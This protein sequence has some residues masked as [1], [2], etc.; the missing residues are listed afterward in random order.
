MGVPVI[1]CSC[2]VCRSSLPHN[3]RT[4]SGSLITI[5]D[6]KILIDASQ[7]F[8]DQALRF[9][10]ASIDAIFFT[11]AHYDHTAGIDD[12]RA[13]KK[14]LP[15]YMSRSTYEDLKGRYGYIFEKRKKER[16][17]LVSDFEISFLG[18]ERGSVDICAVSFN[19]MTYEQVGMPVNGFVLGNLGY[20]S[21]I[22]TYPTTIFEDL[23]GVEIL[24]VSALRQAPS[25]IHFSIDE[26]IDFSR[27][28]GA[29]KTYLTHLSHEIEHE[30]TQRSLP[31]N[32]FLAYDGLEVFF[33]VDDR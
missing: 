30:K 22:K 27:M 10:L 23:K 2:E 13:Y 19:Y 31:E 24:I 3:Q 17:T 21:D 1:G 25:H 29:K 15:C 28:V 8:R 7:D 6:K 32:V 18:E 5:N 9:H 16:K 14:K 33:T 12:L 11:H 26:A 4:R 20:V